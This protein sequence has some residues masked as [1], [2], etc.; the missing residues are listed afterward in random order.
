MEIAAHQQ[1]AD[2]IARAMLK[3]FRKGDA[4]AFETI[5]ARAYGKPQQQADETGKMNVSVIIDL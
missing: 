5:A 2:A 4:K 1:N 3:K